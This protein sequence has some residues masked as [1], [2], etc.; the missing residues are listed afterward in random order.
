MSVVLKRPQ[1]IFTLCLVL[2][3]AAVLGWMAARQ[4]KLSQKTYRIGFDNQAPQHFLTSDGKPAG[5]AIDLIGEAARRSAIRLQW[6][7]EPESAEAAL[8]SKKVD[9][10]PM[11][12][13]TPERRGV[14][15]ITDPYRE[16]VVCLIVRRESPYKRLE[17]LRHSAISYDGTPIDLRLLRSRLPDARFSVIDTPKERL[18]AVCRQSVDAAHFD[19]YTAVTALLYGVVCGGQGLRFIEVPELSGR[20]GVGATFEARPAADAI[21]KEI[22]NMAADGS[23]AEIGARWRSFSGRNLELADE[24]VHAQLRERWLIAGMS[25]VVVLLVLTLWQAGRIRRAQVAMGEKNKELVVALARAKEATEL[26]S[27]FLANMSH[28][29]R[30]PM[31][32]VIGMLGLL[33]ETPPLTSEQQEFAEAAHDSARAL[34]TILNDIL[35]F[36]KI[37]AGKLTFEKLDFDPA[38]VVRGV[39]RL[40]ADG[41]KGKGLEFVCGIPEPLPDQV[42]GDPMRLRQVLMNLAGNAIKFT[43][44]G[45]VDLRVT[46]ESESENSV[47]LRFAVTDTGIGISDEEQ[48]RIFEPFAQADGSMARKYGGTGLGLSISTQLIASMGGELRVESTPARGSTFWFVLPF[49]KARVGVDGIKS[50]LRILDTEQSPN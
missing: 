4:S 44:N 30:T 6:Q 49:E 28:E 14:V 9:L 35:D 8:K 23:L 5:L 18:E 7:L 26:R 19:E 31:N 47:N 38:E 17:D 24:L 16:N 10:W 41:A 29:I 48:R 22:G 33:L 37:A 25:T 27:Q 42:R 15:Y 50:E 13:I 34:L 1:W 3:V 39:W 20:L 40:L 32:G 11:M 45:L 46:V 12:T 21:R 36:S 2:V 43:G